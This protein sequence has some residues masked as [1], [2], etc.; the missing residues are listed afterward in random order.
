M[1]F[2]LLIAGTP[3]LEENARLTVEDN[4]IGTALRGVGDVDGDGFDDV[5]VGLPGDDTYGENTG[6]VMAWYGSATGLD[7]DAG[8]LIAPDDAADRDVNG[9]A[10]AAAGDVNGD[11]IA[12]ALVGN[13]WSH[14]TNINSAYVF[15][16]SLTGLDP[17]ERTRVMPLD[18]HTGR[19]FGRHV[20]GLGDVDA[21]G[22]ADVLIGARLDNT[23]VG[24]G[25]AYVYYGGP[26]GIEPESEVRVEPD[27][28]A[29]DDEFGAGVAGVGDLDGDGYP[30]FAVGAAEQ[31]AVY[32]FH[33]GVTAEPDR[34]DPPTSESN[35]GWTID[36][37]GDVDGD[38]YADLATVGRTT[39]TIYAYFGGWG[40][41]A[42]QAELGS[43]AYGTVAG[44][45]D[46]DGDGFAD[47]GAWDAGTTERFALLMGSADGIDASPHYFE[48]EESERYFGHVQPAGD[49]NADG[50]ADLLVGAR[51][52]GDHGA[53][54][55]YTSTCPSWYA[56]EDG[57]GHGGGPAV[58]DCGEPDGHVTNRSDCDDADGGVYTGA[59][60]TCDDRDEDCD[61]RVDE[62]VVDAWADS[63][64]DGFGDPDLAVTDC[65]TPWADN[66]ADCDDQDASIWPG[67]PELC[68][69]ED[70]DCDSRVDEGATATWFRDA[71]GDGFSTDEAAEDCVAPPGFGVGSDELDC[72][73]DDPSVFPGAP[74]PPGDG[75]DQDCDGRDA[76]RAPAPEGCGCAT[77]SPAALAFVL[78]IRRRRR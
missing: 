41:V 62:G 20:A 61:G 60:E 67:A 31:E 63:D 2:A 66:A 37:L 24:G 70:D 75:V 13:C 47:V 76:R 36:G 49:L 7:P 46:V 19:R 39:D 3:G 72:D 45:G 65:D 18:G 8:V 34:L 77:G 71:D 32:V 58:Q 4:S 22:F 1:I 69:D 30:D 15:Y 54:V 38:G 11:G 50:F 29:D 55:V 27:G 42:D 48:R 53:V 12:D 59:V 57:D 10:I 44:V 56:D 73:D 33:D 64:G 78:L 14:G 52:D 26:H 35:F 74:D 5:L 23:T 16:G 25:A 9:C 51:W 21:D 6:A 17:S 43:G 28:L 40:G 68:N